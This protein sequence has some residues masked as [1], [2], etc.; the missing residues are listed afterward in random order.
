MVGS[1]PQMFYL[2]PLGDR[3]QASHATTNASLGFPVSA[4]T[5]IWKQAL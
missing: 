5:P 1:R 3:T 2:H 4:I